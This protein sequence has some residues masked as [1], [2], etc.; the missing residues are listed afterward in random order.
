MHYAELADAHCHLDLFEN[1]EKVIMDS[2]ADG[3]KVMIT[4]GGS[5]K[6]NQATLKLTGNQHVFGVVGIDPS[7][8]ASDS[9][10]IGELE[11][12]LKSSKHIVGIGEV[13]LDVKVTSASH[14][15]QKKAFAEQISIAKSL[16]VPVVIH[17]RGMIKEVIEIV[18]EEKLER[19]MFHFFEGNAEQAAE[20]AKRGF[21]ISIPPVG[22]DRRK[23]IINVVDEHNIVAESDS[24][25][26][27]KTP[28]EILN[29][30]SMVAEVKGLDLSDAA[31]SLTENVK[32]FFY[33]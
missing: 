15:M 17:S 12:L 29:V 7:F 9:R 8:V 31:F 20:L 1:P 22:L 16:D 33:I 5:D 2:V 24:P 13:G 14:D 23:R 30:I 27:G 4:A 6:S 18:R 28:A 3:V 21:M 26:A 32:K 19:A 10:H 11:R 25:A